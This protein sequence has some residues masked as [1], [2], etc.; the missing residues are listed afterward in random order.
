V[1]PAGRAALLWDG[2][3][4]PLGAHFGGDRAEA[5]VTL[6]PGS[7]L[8]LYTDGL[9]ERRDEPLDACIDRLASLL[10]E[11]AAQPLTGLADSVTETALGTRRTGD[12]VCLLLV[13][14]EEDPTFSRS[15]PADSSRVAALRAD[16]TQWLQSHGVVGQDHD[17][18]VLAC[19]E[20][21]SNAIE[22]G[23]A[24]DRSGMVDVLATL[25]PGL[26]RIRVRDR[27][28]WRAPGS[29]GHRGRGLPLIRA[30]MDHVS[31]EHTTGTVV[32]MRRRILQGAVT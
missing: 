17:A 28:L 4:A 30:L 9:V 1:D 27:G 20:A 26:L 5:E 23:Y 2:R 18:T 19:S 21:V 15:V 14:F 11:S 6:V 13:A 32:S 24:D 25:S 10:G 29:P 22:H 31:V 12:D 3:S 8:A 16:L 7:R